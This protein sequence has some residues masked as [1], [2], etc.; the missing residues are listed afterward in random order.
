MFTTET[1]SQSK[2]DDYLKKKNTNNPDPRQ[3]L[4]HSHVNE[5]ST[6]RD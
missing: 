2:Q 5:D 1:L 6:N 4:K 3:M